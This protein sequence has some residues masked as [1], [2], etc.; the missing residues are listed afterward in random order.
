M[1]KTGRGFWF[2]LGPF[3][4]QKVNWAVKIKLKEVI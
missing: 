2:L 4:G 3:F 1:T